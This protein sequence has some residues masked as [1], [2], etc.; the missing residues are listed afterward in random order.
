ML[1]E[2][3]PAL[4]A[5]REVAVKYHKLRFATQFPTLASVVSYSEFASHPHLRPGVQSRAHKGLDVHQRDL[6]RVEAL[7]VEARVIEAAVEEALVSGVL[8]EAR[9]D[10]CDDR[11][12]RDT[13]LEDFHEQL[14]QARGQR[15]AV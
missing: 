10:V 5:F 7:I 12:G 4:G 9:G 11:G 14:A 13:R 15:L 1:A 3:T 2:T 6:A 8:C